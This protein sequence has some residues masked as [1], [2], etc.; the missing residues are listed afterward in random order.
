MMLKHLDAL[1]DDEAPIHRINFE[2]KTKYQSALGGLC[3]LTL[4]F[5]FLFVLYIEA[6]EV[7]N[8]KYPFVQTREV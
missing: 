1:A 4:I 6:D 7:I 2:E 3:T 8:K 5:V